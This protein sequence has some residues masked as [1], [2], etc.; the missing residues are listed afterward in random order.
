MP[1]LL[2]ILLAGL[3]IYL[4][5]RVSEQAKR[6]AS[7]PPGPRGL[8]LVGNLFDMPTSNQWMKFA[9]WGKKYG[10]ICFVTIFG[11]PIIILNTAKAAI[12]IL[13]KKSAIYS[14]RPT[15]LMVGELAGWN[16]MLVL[17]PYGEKSRLHRKLLYKTIGTAK[18]V[19]RLVPIAEAETRRFINRVISK[20]E[21]L[22]TQIRHS[23][24]AIILL[25][26][27][28]YE[29]QEHHD[30][31]VDLVE[32]ADS[33]FSECTTPG[34]FWVDVVP[35]FRYVPEWFPGAG[36]KRLAKEFRQTLHDMVERPFAFVKE[37]M[38][39]G[40]AVPSYTHELLEK[41]GLTADEELAIKWSAASLYSGGGDTTISAIHAFFLAMTLYPEVQK[42]A[43]AEIEAVVGTHTLPTYTDR[44]RL[45]YVDALVKEVLRWNTVVPLAPHCVLEEDVHE[46][47]RIPAGSTVIANLDNML[48]DP[49]TYPNPSVFDPTRFI[50]SEGKVPQKDPRSI[51]FGFGR[52]VCPGIH[53]ADM[54]VFSSCVMALATL[55]IAKYVEN[56]MVVEP[57]MDKTPGSVNHPVPFKCSIT[58][59]A[60]Y[61]NGIPG[62]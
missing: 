58:A 2:S 28:G 4:L 50:P 53:F 29:V 51:C 39:T 49:L 5:Q 60:P 45:P 10:D 13:E 21:D 37:Q 22:A 52:R 17:S 44:E 23:A 59:R 46:G 14:D 27:Y 20:P 57:V 19:Q 8:P 1:A 34:A 62:N 55:N 9:E 47:Y 56:G 6:R 25:V 16:D 12:D 54:T 3:A 35:I 33:Q 48:H 7:L 32:R 61:G 30:P 26:S 41:K 11:K 38:D 42:Q 43:Q 15:F 40:N 36:F 31:F 24:G 18:S